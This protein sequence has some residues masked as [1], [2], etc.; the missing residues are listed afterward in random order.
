[1]SVRLVKH[2]TPTT[3]EA[4][5]A[6][7]KKGREGELFVK[8]AIESWGWLV[9]DNEADVNSQVT[10]CD[11]FIQNP[12]WFNAYS[13]DVKANINKYG[14]FLIYPDEWMD[15]RKQNDRFWHVNVE[16]G[17]MAWYSRQD[18]QS[19]IKRNKLTE[20]F[21]VRVKGEQPFKITRRKHAI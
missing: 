4:F 5:G 10:G 15:P 7:G 12:E 19:Y 17:W 2:W 11:L 14:S 13:V 9:T 3:E 18:V 20:P 8:K 21:E 1:M 6:R 16:S